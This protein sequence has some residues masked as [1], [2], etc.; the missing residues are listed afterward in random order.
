MKVTYPIKLISTLIVLLRSDAHISMVSD[1]LGLRDTIKVSKL[2]QRY[3]SLLQRYIKLVYSGNMKRFG[4]LLLSL[5]GLRTKAM[6]IS[7]TFESFIIMDRT[8]VAGLVDNCLLETVEP[9][10]MTV[11]QVVISTATPADLADVNQ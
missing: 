4:R 11:D 3:L 10:E 8:P 2:Q 5:P 9:E 6:N 7:E 1:A